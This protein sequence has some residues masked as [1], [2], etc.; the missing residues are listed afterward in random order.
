MSSL[1]LKNDKRIQEIARSI[2][3][4]VHGYYEEIWPVSIYGIR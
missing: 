1:H 3:A 4:L 2:V